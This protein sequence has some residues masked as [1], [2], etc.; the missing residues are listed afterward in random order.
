VVLI[1]IWAFSCLYMS[2]FVPAL[3]GP[4]PCP[5]MDRDLGAYPARYNGP[6]RP[7]TK[8]FRAVPCLGRVFFPCFG[9]AHLARPKCTPIAAAALPL[10]HC[11]TLPQVRPGQRQRQRLSFVFLKEGVKVLPRSILLEGK[12]KYKLQET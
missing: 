12:E 8:L 4:C 9:P 6:C 7:G 1:N 5:P 10:R 2:H 3:N 11:A